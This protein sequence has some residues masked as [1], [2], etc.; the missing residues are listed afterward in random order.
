MEN[1]NSFPYYDDFNPTKNFHR[2]LFK[3]GVA[4]Q[5]RELTQ[6][7]TIVQNQISQFA[8]GIYSQN[9]PVSGGKVTTNLNCFYLKLNST[10]NNNAVVAATLLGQIIT[11]STGF[12][13]A[14]VIATAEA[15]GTTVAVG[16]PPTL[17]ISYISGVQFTD[18]VTIYTNINGALQPQATSIGI[19]TGQSTCTGLSSTASV[20]A[21]VFWIIN[22]Y[23]TVQNPDGTSSQYQIGNFVNVNPQTIILDKY[24]NTPNVRIGLSI[25]ESV[26][27]Y[28]Q[29]ATLLDPAVSATNYQAPGADRYAITLNLVTQPLTLGNDS[30]FI[31]LIRMSNGIILKQTN[32]TVYSAIDDYFAKRDYE[33]N[34]DYVVE[35]FKLTPIPNAAGNKSYYDMVVGKGVAYVHG[36]RIENQSNLRLTTPRAQNTA[37]VYSSNNNINI[38]YGNYFVVDTSN[39]VFDVAQ[40]PQIDIHCVPAQSVNTWTANS[41]ASTLIGSGFIRSLQYVYSTS[42]NTKSYVYNAYVNDIINNTLNATGNSTLQGSITTSNTLQIAIYDPTFSLS[43]VANAYYGATLSITSGTGVGSSRTITGWNQ[44]GSN[45]NTK[46]ANVSSALLFTPDTTSKLSIIF[47]NSVANSIIQKSNTGGTGA[48]AAQA[49]YA[50]AANVNINIASGKVSGVPTGAAI[51][52][53]PTQPEMIFPIGNAWVANNTLNNITYYGTQVFRGLSFNQTS[54]SFTISTTGPVYF[55]AGV[56]QTLYGDPFR[57]LFTVVDNNT[58]QI[59]DFSTTANTAT[60]NSNQQVTFNSAAYSATGRAGNNLTI[61]AGIYFN[62]ATIPDSSGTIV[63]TKT[64]ILGNTIQTSASIPTYSIGI[65]GS[66]P[67]GGSNVSAWIDTSVGQTYISANVASNTSAPISLYVSDVKS[68][69]AIYDTGSPATI[70]TP[71]AS[72]AA[73]GYRNITSSYVLNNGQKDSFYD[74]AYIKLQPGATPPIGNLLV[75]Y[76]YYQHG[77]GDGFFAGA[78]SYL[79]PSSPETYTGIQSYTAK[80]GTTYQLRDCLDF[81]PTRAAGNNITSY[82]WEYHNAPTSSTNGGLFLP[83]NNKPLTSGY[84]YYLS[85]K[86]K[87]VLTKDSKFRMI[88][89]VPA[90]NSIYPNEPDGSLVLAKIALDPYTAYVPGEGPSVSS[91]NYSYGVN[92]GSIPVNLAVTKVL[93]K[94]WAKQDITALQAQVDNLEYYTALSLLEQNANSLQTPDVNGLNRFKNGI[95]VDDFSSFATADTSVNNFNANINIRTK[96]LGPVQF[97]NNYQL[98]NP[99]VLGSLGTLASGTNGYTINST[100]GTQTNLYTL[101]YTTANVVVQQLASN[102]ISVNPFSVAVYAGAMTMNPPMDNWINTYEAP[103]V[104]I[105][106][107]QFQ[108]TSTSGGL[109]LANGG[110]FASIPGTTQIV[111]CTTTPAASQSYA[112]Q[113]TGLNNATGTSS[114]AATPLSVQNGYVTNTGQQAYIRTQEIIIRA[115]GLLHNAYLS[116]WFD[117]VNVTKYMKM[118]HTI[119]LTGVKGTFNDDDIIGFYSTSTSKFYPIGRV[120]TSYQYP[121]NNQ[122]RLYISDYVQMPNVTFTSTLINASFSAN[123]SFTGSTAAGNV[124][125]N[126]SGTNFSPSVLFLHTSGTVGGVGGTYISANPANAISS[127]IYKSEPVAGYSTLFNNYAVWGDPNN[128]TSYNQFGWINYGSPA[129]SIGGIL[130]PNTAYSINYSGTGSGTFNIGYYPSGTIPS[131]ANAVY[132]INTTISPNPTGVS[133]ISLPASGITNSGNATNVFVQYSLSASPKQTQGFGLTISDASGVIVYD[134]LTPGTLNFT[135]SSN[136]SSQLSM[137]QGGTYYQ[138]VKQVNFPSSASTANSFYNGAQIQIRSIYVYSFHN[139]AIYYPPNIV[140]GR[141]V[142]Y[143]YGDTDAPVWVDYSYDCATADALDA[144]KQVAQKNSLSYTVLEQS[145][146]ANVTDY[147][148]P[149]RTATLDIPVNISMGNNASF[150]PVTSTYTLVGPPNIGI[151]QA[152]SSANTFPQLS[153]DEYGNF[154]GVFNLPGS[155]F[156]QGQRIFRLDNRNLASGDPASA[157]T[158]AEATFYAGGIQGQVSTPS[159]T[160]DSGSSLINPLQNSGYNIISAPSLMD[161]IAQTFIIDKNNY[162]NGAFLSDLKLFFAPYRGSVPKANGVPTITL[163]PVTV[164]IVET[165][166]GLPNGKTL[167]HSKVTLT[168]DKIVTSNT[169]YYANS[170]TYTQF[171]FPAPVY[172]QSGVLY[173]FTVHS[174]SSDYTLYYGGQNEPAIPSTTNGVVSKIGAAP[175]VGALFES[176][177]GQTWTA[178]Q[179][180]DL[181]FVLDQCIFPT[182]VSATIPFVIPQGL[183]TRK[184]G[185][186]EVKFFYDPLIVPNTHGKIS[187]QKFKAVHALNMTT[188]DFV[189]S[190]TSISY[191]YQATLASTLGLYPS[192]PT[193][194]NPGK[195]GAPT[196]DNVYLSDSQGSRLLVKGANNSFTMYATLTNGSDPYVSPILSDD[197]LTLYTITYQI[198]NMGIT[199]NL[200]SVANTGSGYSNNG[201]IIITSGL[202]KSNI[203]NDLGTNDLPVFGYTTNAISGAINTIYTTYPGSGYLATPTITI[204]DPTTR[205]TGNANAVF[206]VSGETSTSGGNAKARYYTKKVIMTPGN[207]SGDLRVFYS[208]YKPPGSAIYVYYKILS[209]SD[210]AKLEDQNWQLMTQMGGVGVY[211]TSG[212]RSNIIEYEAAPGNFYSSAANNN[213]NYTSSSGASYNNFI[214]FAIKVVMAASDPTNPPFLTSLQ[215]LALPPGTGI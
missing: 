125:F 173:A 189:P 200:L 67:S 156:F 68:I 146:T 26:V 199:T 14:K 100:L 9:T 50:I 48:S 97:V 131:T 113:A 16:D 81:R 150:G 28:I 92:F 190:N 42:T 215:A 110:D 58:G 106:Q 151:A 98:Q 51:L 31:E 166:N 111:A 56:N 99:S 89:G 158:Y 49:I 32:D 86:D 130:K 112:S 154:V 22:G 7:Q 107:P 52:N 187:P 21:G 63:K 74:Y 90:I 105:T 165:L 23:N 24:D 109:T 8:S 169:P 186:A 148:G 140:T 134:T 211:S 34:G 84:Q 168:G 143:P 73:L 157:T 37:T 116:A 138:G 78:S 43:N 114:A 83:Q 64:L 198:N 79:S 76:N 133:T 206:T 176:Q 191:A 194:I 70:L 41:Y 145:F 104:T 136:V 75:C 144:A 205:Q 95:L 66:A 59:L 38:N 39:G 1:F 60:A 124:T 153:S 11:D 214:Q 164:S 195:Y 80:D 141:Y 33:T 184:L 132:V 188:T 119:E 36:Y 19:V 180:R 163:P 175:Y 118:P 142:T 20:S 54:N 193:P 61:I 171:T 121:T 174:G 185:S 162:P 13:K 96:I 126:L 77:G 45:S 209:S 155:Q 85:R 46:I 91:G 181:M 55:Q 62:S 69:A 212:N 177:N 12:I 6:S 178:D 65:V 123:G 207:D 122:T 47:T 57:T 15:T 25:V 40:S 160:V 102:V 2:I 17:I 117:G 203:T 53:N 213:I 94:R 167:N 120:V 44:Y 127:S 88:L 82:T 35:D 4:V 161:P 137:P 87:L 108:F 18:G 201:T 29:D 208:A 72:I 182:N 179:S 10:Y 197:G 101:P 192:S 210:T 128:G 135:N 152:V 172:V 147:Y 30:S 202:A 5:A 71:N 159:A 3:P 204:S 170:S 139:A 115:K 149:T 27:N 93:H 183:P 196:M 129:T 103:V